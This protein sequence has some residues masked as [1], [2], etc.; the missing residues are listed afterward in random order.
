[1]FMN[2]EKNTSNISTLSLAQSIQYLGGA[3]EMKV[4]KVFPSRDG[5]SS[6][7]NK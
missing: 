7:Q 1:M 2:S 4:E 6:T 3:L 5:L